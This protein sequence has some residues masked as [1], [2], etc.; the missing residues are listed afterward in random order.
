MVFAVMLMVL[1]LTESLDID[2]GPGCGL[3]VFSFI[4]LM[5]ELAIYANHLH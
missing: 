3:A 4:E 1:V 2:S 5:V